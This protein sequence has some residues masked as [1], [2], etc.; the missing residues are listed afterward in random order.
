MHFSHT[1]NQK[2]ESCNN[3]CDVCHGNSWTV[4]NICICGAAELIDNS[5][6]YC[7]KH[8]TPTINIRTNI[9]AVLPCIPK[10]RSR[11]KYKPNFSMIKLLETIDYTYI[12]VFDA[13]DIASSIGYE[14]NS[15]RD[16]NFNVNTDRNTIILKDTAVTECEP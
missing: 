3:T 15:Y 4:F 16:R 11:E 9:L 13:N 10:A 5:A 14:F 6:R 2:L 8:R 7:S 1:K 12:H